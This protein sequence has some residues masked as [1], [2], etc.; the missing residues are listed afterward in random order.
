MFA[1]H[2]NPGLAASE[3]V[4]KLQQRNLVPRVL[5]DGIFQRMKYFPFRESPHFFNRA[6]AKKSVGIYLVRCNFERCMI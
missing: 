5:D 3:L 6:L 2:T 1:K 4:E